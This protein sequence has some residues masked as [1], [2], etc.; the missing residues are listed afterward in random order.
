MQ[1]G[2]GAMSSL[3]PRMPA[4]FRTDGQTRRRCDRRPVAGDQHRSENDEPEPR[5]TVGTVT[6]IYDYLR[7]LF[8]RIGKPVCPVHGIE[9]TS[10]TIEQMTD[11]IL[12]YPERTKIQVLAPIVSGRK[13]SHVKV[14]DQIRKQGYVRVRIDGE[15]NDL[16]EDIELEKNKKHSIEVVVDRIVIKEGVA[17]RL[18]DSLETALRLGEGRVII[19]VIGQE[20]L[21]F[22]EHHACPHCGFSIGEL[23]PRMFS[24]N[25][26]FGACPSCDGLGSK[27]EVDVELVIPNDELSLKENAIAPWEPQSSQY[28][29]KLLEAVC[30]HYGI[31]MDVP[32]RS[33]R[34]T[35]LKK[36][37][38][39]AETS[40]FIS[41]MKTTSDRSGKTTLSSK[42]SSAISKGAIKKRALITFGN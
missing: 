33:C 29:P 30:S 1:R 26:P 42:A 4:S 13:G 41:D 11:R 20:E 18:T 23:E 34:S 39:A 6:E 14:L 3:S 21:L 9:I 35:S 31:D 15:M 17:A 22:S 37:F 36:S 16:S 10:Q 8:A 40:R 38:T 24:F 32:V 25:S 28:Y 2:N 5:S 12:E 27:L 7:L 19:D